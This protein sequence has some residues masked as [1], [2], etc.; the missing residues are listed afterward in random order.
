MATSKRF[1]PYPTPKGAAEPDGDQPFFISRHEVPS[2]AQQQLGLV[3]TRVGCNV[4]ELPHDHLRNR[5]L[6]SYAAIWVTEGKAWFESPPT[7]RIEVRAG[8]F[9]WLFPTVIHSYS[10]LDCRWSCRWFLFDGAMAQ[11]F[12]RQGFL[13]PANP[14]VDVGDDAEVGALFTRLEQLFLDGG[15][16]AVPLGAALVH[17]LV[18]LVH[19]IGSGLI[20]GGSE[21]GSIVARAARMIESAAGV[22][23]D[24][25]DPE[26]IAARLNTGYST[27]RR[28]FRAQTGYSLKEYMLRVRLK[29]AKNLLALSPMTIEQVASETGFSDPYYFS[30]LFR[31]REGVAPSVFRKNPV[32]EP[33]RPT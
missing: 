22:G 29:R 18:V 31:K 9:L 27:L 23:A 25:A 21:S 4:R 28:Q 17:Q 15:P 24:S 13:T 2:A 14:F 19:G 10:P 33:G 3:V 30:R 11:A 8:T 1:P 16:L 12:E 32:M 5:V 6:G 26:S 20:G 7:G